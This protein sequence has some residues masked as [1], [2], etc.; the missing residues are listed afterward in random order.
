M[1]TGKIQAFLFVAPVAI[2]LGRASYLATVRSR[3]VTR[4]VSAQN[5]MAAADTESP[6]LPEAENADGSDSDDFFRIFYGTD[7]RSP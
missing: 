5:A 2:P 3:P 1:R 4:S 7:S 6:E